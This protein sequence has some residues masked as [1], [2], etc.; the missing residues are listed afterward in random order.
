MF[1]GDADVQ[2]SGWLSMGHGGILG[3]FDALLV[4][5]AGRLSRDHLAGVLRPIW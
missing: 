5:R 3:R 4:F 1:K 2:D